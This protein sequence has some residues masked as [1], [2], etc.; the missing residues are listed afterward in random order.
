VDFISKIQSQYTV[1]DVQEGRAEAVSVVSESELESLIQKQIDEQTAALKREVQDL[2]EQLENADGDGGGGLEEAAAEAA[3][4]AEAVALEGKAQAEQRAAEADAKVK[5]LEAQLADAGDPEKITE[6]EEKVVQLQAE[7]DRMPVLV[8]E[9][10][11]LRHKAEEEA[12]LGSAD[13]PTD[14]EKKK[15]GQLAEAFLDDV[16]TDDEDKTNAAIK[17]GKFRTVFEKELKI[18]KA[19]YVK[20]VKAHVRAENDYWEDCLKAGEAK[21]W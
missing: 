19:K 17:D 16:F 4:E 6:L 7:V 9:I 5:E 14:A 15:A 3:L 8:A 18:A 2:R 1:D 13:P 10:E 11:E 20:R 12:A 21:E